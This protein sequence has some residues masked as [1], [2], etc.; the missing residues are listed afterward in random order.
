MPGLV[1]RCD[2]RRPVQESEAGECRDANEDHN[3]GYDGVNGRGCPGGNE[4]INPN[5]QEPLTN[6]A[7]QCWTISNFAPGYGQDDDD[8]GG[9]GSPGE[10]DD[11]EGGG[12]SPGEEDDDEGGSSPGEEDDDEEGDKTY[13][14]NI[15]GTCGGT[16]AQT[17]VTS[18]DECAEAAEALD[19]SDVTTSRINSANRPP[20]C[21]FK[22]SNAR[23]QLY[24]NANMGADRV[25]RQ[26]P[27]ICR[28]TGDEPPPSFALREV[29]NCNGAYDYV[30]SESEC[31]EAAEALDLEDTTAT[32]LEDKPSRP[33]GCYYK[34]DNRRRKLYFN[35]G[36]DRDSNDTARVSVCGVNARR[37]RRVNLEAEAIESKK[38]FLRG[39]AVGAE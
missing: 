7:D 27:V 25:D 14:L 29:G 28:T 26:R 22:P 39:R 37:D 12:G 30:A 33:H 38:F 2:Y 8:E 23:Q 6:T 1:D 20:G 36:G 18:R 19:L 35:A 11:D 16:E 21:F 17:A 15:A 32:L 3:R 10:G 24:W 13:V 34:E 5:F 9:G 4:A 31:E